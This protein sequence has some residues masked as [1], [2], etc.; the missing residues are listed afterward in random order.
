MSDIPIIGE[1]GYVTVPEEELTA[2]EI[3]L[4]S[5][6]L[7]AITA[8]L[9]ADGDTRD[10]AADKVGEFE[11]ESVHGIQ[12]VT[13]LDLIVDLDIDDRLPETFYLQPSK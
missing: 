3:S 8:Y 13:D 2:E 4:A 6:H 5:R 10:A 12:V 9:N 1:E 11:G 7:N